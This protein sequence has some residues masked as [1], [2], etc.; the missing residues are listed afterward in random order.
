MLNSKD[1]QEGIAELSAVQQLNAGRSTEEM[2]RQ[3]FQAK[4]LGASQSQLESAS[5]SLLDFESSIGAEMEAEL[6]TGKQ[7]NLEA[8]RA[9]ALAGDQG[10]LAEELVKNGVKELLIVSQDTGAYGNDLKDKNPIDRAK[11]I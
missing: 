1:I 8:A 9:A 6:L 10:K 3:V 7:L 4:L 5:S 11:K 2:A